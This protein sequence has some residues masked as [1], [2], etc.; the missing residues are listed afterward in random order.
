MRCNAA[1][2]LPRDYERVIA[3]DSDSGAIVSR[4]TASGC[5]RPTA[6]APGSGSFGVAVDGTDIYWGDK[7]GGRVLRCPL[8]GCSGSPTVI[9]TG[10]TFLY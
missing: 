2:R 10:Q 7:A 5:S 3:I 4:M 6:V 9:A 8:A 1:H